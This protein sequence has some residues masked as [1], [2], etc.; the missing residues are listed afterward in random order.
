MHNLLTKL[1]ERRGIKDVTELSKEEMADFTAWQ[2]VLRNDEVTVATILDF[3]NAEIGRIETQFKNTDDSNE[4]K[5]R[6]TMLHGVY[7]SIR[8]VIS[9]P[10]LERES[11]VKHL[12][13]LISS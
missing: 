13:S 10:R 8:N 12:E 5:A 9:K 3:C 1:L 4:K 2:S 6:L 11:V 7:S